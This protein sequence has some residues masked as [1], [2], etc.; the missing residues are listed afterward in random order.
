MEQTGAY[1]IPASREQV[2]VA[3]NNPDILGACITGCQEV[4]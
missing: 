4:I 1:D 2:W 3:L